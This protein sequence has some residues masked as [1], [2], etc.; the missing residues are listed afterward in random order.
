VEKPKTLLAALIGRY[1]HPLILLADA[2][3][4]SSSKLA[5]DALA[6]TT[7]D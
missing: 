1:S 2:V 4:L 5:I 3:E 6:L 7:T